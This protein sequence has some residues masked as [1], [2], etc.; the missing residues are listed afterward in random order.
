MDRFNALGRGMQIMLVGGV[1]L[2]ID[3][4]L[5]WQDFGDVLGIDVSFKGWRGIGVI[6][7]ILTIALVAWIA[8]R[9]ASVDI[10]LPVSSELIS[11]ALGV[12]ILAFGIIKWLTI[13]DDEATLWAW[14]GLILSVAIAVGAWLT[15]QAAGGMA[16]LR[17]EMQ[18]MQS[19]SPSS[20]AAAPPAAPEP[21]AAPPAAPP[22]PPAPAGAPPMS[23]PASP[24]TESG[25]EPAREN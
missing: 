24:G 10:R 6:L 11:A 25:D 2:F 18:T 1:L 21:P 3:L 7:G 15:V 19:S 8:L 12:L 20:T 22:P 9:L 17:S 14:I 16:T 13:I 5:P 4:F 23:E